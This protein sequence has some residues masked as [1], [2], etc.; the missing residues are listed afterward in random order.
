VYL[1]VDWRRVGSGRGRKAR[2][3]W[4]WE[5][6]THKK[7][8]RWPGY[9]AG[10]RCKDRCHVHSRRLEANPTYSSSPLY[11]FF[12]WASSFLIFFF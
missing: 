4:R 8:M 6:A 5:A 11:L 2:R 1:V 7:A 9:L 12:S 3:S 10:H